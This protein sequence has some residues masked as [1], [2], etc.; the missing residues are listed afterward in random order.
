MAQHQDEDGE[1][2]VA[3]GMEGLKKPPDLIHSHTLSQWHA[4]MIGLMTPGQRTTHGTRKPPSQMV[5]FSPQNGVVSPSGQLIEIAE[6]PLTSTER[7][8]THPPIQR[9]DAFTWG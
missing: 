7:H 6:E 3:E 4:T 8:Q 2:Q 1:Q 9:H 5:P